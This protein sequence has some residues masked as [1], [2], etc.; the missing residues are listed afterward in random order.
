[1][2]GGQQPLAL[3]W[4]DG[5]HF[6][7]YY[8]GH[9]NADAVA[10]L[11]QALGEGDC[12]ICLHGPE[13]S[14][15]THLCLAAA[16]A[17]G[18]AGYYLSLRRPRVEALALLEQQ[19]AVPLLCLDDAHRLLGDRDS[20]KVLFDVHNRVRDGGGTLL[21]T[22]RG[23]VADNDFALADLRSRWRGAIQIH[24]R[25]LSDQELAKGWSERAKLR[26]LQPD[27]AVI[28]WLLTHRRRNFSDWMDTLERLDR[29]ALAAGRRL[30]LP[31]VRGLLKGP[32]PGAEG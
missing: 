8:P 11:R 5:G 18:D 2:T 3:S 15:R 16:D 24:L 13:G 12:S 31:F 32:T 6:H 26:G 21:Y 29:A 19:G 28:S 7:D 22:Q 17:A 1:M 27:P 30:T 4:R 14:G 9:S 23:D 10:L 20:E 25:A